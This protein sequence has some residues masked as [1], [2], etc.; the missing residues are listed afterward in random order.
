MPSFHRYQ[1][2]A[3]N[4]RRTT[5]AAVRELLNAS[6]APEEIAVITWRGRESSQLLA[7]DTLAD[8][9]LRKFTGR[10]DEA[11]QP[12]WTDGRLQVDSLRR[13]KGQAAPA[14]VLTEVDFDTLGELE[15]HLLFVGM[16]RARMS[17]AVVLTERAEQVLAALLGGA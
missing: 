5:E 10:Y 9:P 17:L 1:P 13:T 8:L 14:V 15:R 2:S 4:L 3:G 7:L 16:T 11:G 6:H 12:L